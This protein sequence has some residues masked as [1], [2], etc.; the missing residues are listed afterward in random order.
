MDEK[1]ILGN[2]KEKIFDNGGSIITQSICLTTIIPTITM[3]VMSDAVKDF[4]WVDDNQ[5]LWISLRTHS[6]KTPDERGRTHYIS[7]N[8]FVPQKQFNNLN[9]T[10]QVN[11]N[12]ARNVQ[13]VFGEECPF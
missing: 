9:N 2:G 6:K 8:T 12:N 10:Q 5:R 11:E 7:V 3:A 13:A 1:I 4:C